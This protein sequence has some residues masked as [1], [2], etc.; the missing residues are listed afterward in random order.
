[1]KKI[2]PA[3]LREALLDHSGPVILYD[4]ETIESNFKKFRRL[5]S[6]SDATWSIAVKALSR[7]EIMEVA[8][9]YVDGFDISNIVEWQKIKSAVQSHHKVWLTNANLQKELDI[10]LNELPAEKLLITVNDLIDLD[11]IIKKNVPYLIRI[12]TSEF[13]FQPGKSRF[14]LSYS[15]LNLHKNQILADKNF[16]G[17]HLHQGLEDHTYK[18]LHSILKSAKDK[19]SAYGGKNYLLNLGG[20]FQ[21]FDDNE[22]LASL[23]LIKDQFKIHIEP[24]RALYKEA[25]F[26]MAP[27]EK[28][29]LEDDCM[30]I[31]TRLSFINHLKWSKPSFAGILN[32]NENIETV[33]VDSLILEGPT[34]Y[35]FDKSEKIMIDMP[36]SFTKGSLIVLDNITGYSAEWNSGFNGVTMCEVK[37]VGR[38]RPGNPE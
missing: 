19:L 36:L 26:A 28:Y 7:P 23:N 16:K 9:S 33:H 1:M 17:F 13:I 14:G 18:I 30:R 37:F 32:M 25:G 38:R 20:S 10:F 15:D 4:Y 35:E 24:G 12:A 31:F 22:I 3:I 21:S 5:T 11:Y 29:I 34:C 6:L 2:K 8:K 27:I